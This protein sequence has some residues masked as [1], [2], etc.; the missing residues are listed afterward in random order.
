MQNIKIMDITITYRLKYMF[1]SHNHICKSVC[2]RYFNTQKGSE[3]FIK[4]NGGS[5]GIWL[6]RRTFLI[7]SK[8]SEN[9]DDIPKYKTFSNDY[10]TNLK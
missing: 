9:L 2:N 6:D 7:E 8:I 4:K 10:L 3:I 5:K 1:K